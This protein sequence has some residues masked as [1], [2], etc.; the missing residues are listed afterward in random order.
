VDLIFISLSWNIRIFHLILQKFLQKFFKKYRLM[1]A[2]EFKTKIFENK[3]LIP[4]RRQQELISEVGKKV[5]VVV[6]VEDDEVYDQKLYHNLARSQFLKGY[7]DTDA[8][9]DM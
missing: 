6:F 9:Y 2:V 1:K 3:I 5:R 4:R 8:I 7:A